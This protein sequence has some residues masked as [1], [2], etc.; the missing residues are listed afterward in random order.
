MFNTKLHLVNG[1]D[2]PRTYDG[3]SIATPAWSGS[4]LT[5]ADLDGVTS[6]AER[7]IFWDTATQDF[8]YGGVQS[9]SGTLTK[10][11]MS[12]LGKFGGNIVAISP[13]ARVSG[14]DTQEVL[15]IVMSSGEVMIYYGTDPGVAANWTKVSI[16]KIGSPLNIRGVLK[17]ADDLFILTRDD[18]TSLRTIAATGGERKKGISKISGA[19]QTAALAY[20]S[21]FGWAVT[22]HPADNIIVVNVPVSATRF[23]QHVL[24]TTTKAWCRFTGMNGRCWATYNDELYF[25]GGGGKV[26]KYTG[27]NDA[28]E[29]IAADGKQAWGHWGVAQPKLV[30]LVRP[31]VSAQGTLAL[32]F[33]LGFDFK[34]VQVEQ[35]TSSAASGP[36]W[37][38][39][40]WDVNQW[41]PEATPRTDWY[42]AAGEGTD[43]SFRLRYAGK[44]Q[45]V[46]WMRTDFR[47]I[48]EAGL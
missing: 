42:D 3:T 43:I 41:A 32:T 26:Y 39:A 13:W 22:H 16:P 38:V 34:D 9:V 30:T 25:G 29:N 36:L 44:G 21:N 5:V 7:L 48:P 14:D 46:A 19:A 10:F 8:W 35:T 33:G 23:D 45:D 1:A 12:M 11:P 27:T 37:D 4:G 31:V 24:N 20:A 28:G 2:D 40:L 17:Y 15:C 6:Y 47:Y 18:W